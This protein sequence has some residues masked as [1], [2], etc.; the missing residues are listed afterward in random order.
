MPAMC[1]I[2]HLAVTLVVCRYEKA[3]TVVRLM[4]KP[5]RVVLKRGLPLEQRRFASKE[6]IEKKQLV[7]LTRLKVKNKI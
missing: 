7:A 2:V 5:P 4:I 6:F 1:S 3:L